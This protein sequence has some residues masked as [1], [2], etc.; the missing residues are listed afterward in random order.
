MNLNYS[1]DIL[2]LIPELLLCFACVFNLLLSIIF[3][4]KSFIFQVLFLTI[5]ILCAI[6]FSVFLH[7]NYKSF[8]YIFDKS[9]CIHDFTFFLRILILISGLLV[10][11]F[12]S[13]K[14]TILD[15][16]TEF[17]VLLAVILIG[18]QVLGLSNHWCVSFIALEI[19]SISSYCLVGLFSN[20]KTAESSLKYILF[21]IVSSAIMLYGITLFFGLEGTLFFNERKF[22]VPTPLFPAAFA[23]GLISVGLFFKLSIFPFHFWVADV[24]EGTKP[25]ITTIIAV[26]PKIAAIAFILSL[27][28]GYQTL[29]LPIIPPKGYFSIAL[30]SLSI[31]TISIGNLGAFLQKNTLRMLGYSS[32]S[33]AGFILLPLSIGIVG[34]EPTLFYLVFYVLTSFAIFYI[35]HIT[36]FLEINDFSGLSQKYPFFSFLILIVLIAMAGLP[37]TGGFMA[38][39]LVLSSLLQEYDYTKK[40]MFLVFV[41][42]ALINTIFA[43]YYYLKIPYLMYFKSESE[44]ISILEVKTKDYIFII[45]LV[46]I[47]FGIFFMPN[48][49]LK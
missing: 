41:I 39:F 45:L 28:V 8:F 12:I 3:K 27:Y 15:A 38:K 17:L 9:L 40:T 20:K 10:L 11:A 1:R 46:I 2:F 37:P 26:I 25:I 35:L 19:V 31:I 32:I 13:F 42:I 33:H 22:Y 49:F 7:Q 34:V 24:Y 29:N 14:N 5:I 48:L 43:L 47:I 23:F 4:N 18:S 44:K 21:G 36:N 16:S 6:S 30:A